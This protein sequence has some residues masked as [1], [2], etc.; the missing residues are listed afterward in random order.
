MTE[1]MH[2]VSELSELLMRPIDDVVSNG[3]AQYFW[4]YPITSFAE[5]IVAYRRSGDRTPIWR[6][7]VD[8]KVWTSRSALNDYV[9]LLVNPFV[10]ALLAGLVSIHIET[11][12]GFV[13]AT[14]RA[15]GVSGRQ[16]D[17]NTV[18]VTL[19]LTT[20]LFIVNDFFRFFMHY[21][22][23]RVPVLW[24][25]HKVHHSAEVLNFATVDRCHPL[26]TRWYGIGIMAGM[27]VVNGVFIAFFGDHLTVVTF[28]GANIFW[29]G[30]SIVGGVL[31]HSPVWLSFGPHVERW[32]ISPAMHHI[33]HSEDPRHFDKNFGGS[34]SVWDR[35]AGTIYIP[36]GREVGSFGI[37]EETPEYRSLDGLLLLPFVKAFRLLRPAADRSAGDCPVRAG[38]RPLREDA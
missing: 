16:A 29:A 28:A 26:E 11:L 10:Y 31:R 2:H 12:G 36:V 24:E 4:L 34:L 38:D 6:T 27:V 13:V 5:P 25:F 33:H 30:F 9:F 35:M 37:G 22:M 8:R 18:L 1:F 32:I 14:V 19:A 17:G 20:S 7:L 23:H 15:A 3:N 21:L